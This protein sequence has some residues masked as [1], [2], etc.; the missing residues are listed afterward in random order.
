MLRV[1]GTG[2]VVWAGL[3]AFAAPTASKKAEASNVPERPAIA[4]V[5]ADAAASVEEGDG[6]RLPTGA[7]EFDVDLP[8]PSSTL[9]LNAADYGVS[10]SSADNT[11]ALRAAFAAAKARQAAGITLAPGIYRLT[12]DAPLTLDGF[13]DFT[14]EAR[15]VTFVS[16]RKRGAFLAIRK[17]VRTR[18]VGFSLDWDW[19]RDPLASLVRIVHAEKDS[20]DFEF[21]DYEDYPNKDAEVRQFFAWDPQARVVGIED[22]LARGYDKPVKRTWLDGHTVR[23]HD[24]PWAI[25]PGQLYRLQH[26]YYHMG[27][28]EMD[29]NEHLRLEDIT[30]LSTPGHAFHMRGTQHHTLFRRV[31]IVPPSDDPRRVITCTADHLHVASSRGF[32][33]MEDCEFSF[34]ADDM[35]NLHDNASFARFRSKKVLRAL[36]YGNLP[37]GTRIEVRNGDYSPTGFVGTVAD[38]KPVPGEARTF[39]IAFEEDVPQETK[40]GFVLFDLTYDT[41][42]VIIRNCLFRDNRS[43]GILVLARDVTIENNVFRHQT[44]GAIWVQTGYTLKQWSEGYGVSNVVIRGNLFDNTNPTGNGARQRQRT[45]LANVYRKTD[46]SDDAPVYPIL[47]DILIE[48]NTFRDSYG[49]AAYLS[50]VRQVVLRD[51]I[52]EDPT[53]RRHALPYRAQFHLVQAADVQVINNVYR[54][55]PYVPAPGVTYDLESCTGVRVGGNRVL[56]R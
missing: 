17:C 49:V 43:R 15:G 8:R 21:L 22:G 38:V 35:V 10:P 16:R 3:C 24:R 31:N 20:F 12:G 1:F 2:L 41:R 56:A 40:D 52:L 9:V 23:V 4:F 44:Y 53:P 39:D 55:S 14:F 29:S 42:N 36:R 27:G 37:K 26:Y 11:A 34:G 28:F 13:R 5:P 46:P 33:L 25:A 18:L 50:G 54:P 32:I 48:R 45:I 47:R 19:T 30:V 51:N 7:K 6:S